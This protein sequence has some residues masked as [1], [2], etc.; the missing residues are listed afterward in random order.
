MNPAGRVF[1][2]LLAVALATCAASPEGDPVPPPVP[3]PPT[4]PPE[5][6]KPE[7]YVAEAQKVLEE[8]AKAQGTAE[9]TGKEAVT[10]FLVRFQEIHFL[11]PD[12]GDHQLDSAEQ[13][14]AAAEPGGKDRL[15]SEG[16]AAG[17]R[18]V[19]GHSGRVGWVLAGG[20]VRTL[21]DRVRDEADLNALADRRRMLRL[22]Q[23]V[24]FLGNLRGDPVP[25]RLLA[26]EPEATFPRRA[27]KP[28][29]APCRVLE[30]AADPESGDPAVR[31]Y[32]HRE[33]RLP[34]AASFLAEQEGAPGWLLVL[35]YDPRLKREAGAVPEGMVI[36]DWLELFQVPP[37]KD[38]KPV[39]RVQAS[40][41]GLVI[42][43][44]KVPDSLFAV[45]K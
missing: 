3:A 37:A 40:V 16:T 22:A 13:A 41:D 6:R 15:R 34:V 14:F 27:G 7:A 26:D 33:T 29:T 35:Q 12:K 24:F 28:L 39:L 30:R 2:A 21:T 4:P 1:V 9:R 23:R 5:M 43:P 11:D 10:R 17:E 38:E 20:Q 8:A 25:L 18:T 36:P 44:E 42:G 32:L 31:I 19:L 45:P